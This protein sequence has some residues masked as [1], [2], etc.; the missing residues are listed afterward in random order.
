MKR[1]IVPMLA[2]LF[3][4]A[5]TSEKN[6]D[7]VTPQPQAPKGE[8]RPAGTSLGAP[9]TKDIGAAGGNISSADGKLKVTVPAGAI[10][11]NTQFSVEPISNTLPGSPGIAY[12]L[13]PEGVKFAK[14]LTLEFTYNTSDLDSTSE[15][16]LFMAYQAKDGIWRMLPKTQLDR[17][18][19]KLTIQTDHFSDWAPFAM[20]WLTAIKNALKPK[21]STLLSVHVTED[22]LISSLNQDEVEIAREKVLQSADN[23]KNWKV[24]SGGTVTPDAKPFLANYTAPAKVPNPNPVTVSVEIHNFI[25]AG[26]IPGR[27]ATGKAILFKKIRIYE[28]TYFYGTNGGA[29]YN[30]LQHWFFEEDGEDIMLIGGF[31]GT[32]AHFGLYLPKGSGVGTYNMNMHGYVYIEDFSQAGTLIYNTVYTHCI[33]GDDINAAGSIEIT[34]IETLNGV[35]YIEGNFSVGMFKFTSCSPPVK[36]VTGEFRVRDRRSY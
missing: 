26:M 19:Q 6:K 27:G 14:P 20:F 36:K 12:R 4:Y 24:N 31:T 21:E 5:C 18:A 7:N 13:R 35:K 16:A 34:K 15:E 8:V 10:A 23:V 32:A 28:D 1:I 17:T 29:E 25:P 2:I 11:A 3:L 30:T 9:V 33:S 22:F